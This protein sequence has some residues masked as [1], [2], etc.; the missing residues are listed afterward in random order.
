M[1]P[2]AAVD[3]SQPKLPPQ[4]LEA[5]QS[6]LGAILLDN[7]A[8]P[9]AMELL[10][11]EDFY[12][13][14]HRKI[15]RAMLDLSDVGEVIDQITLTERLKAKGE[16]ESVGGAA[17]LAELVQAV[18]SAANIRYHCKIVRDKAVAR[19]LT[20]FI[21]ELKK[22]GGVPSE[23]N[24][25]V[26]TTGVYLNG[27][28]GG[29]SFLLNYPKQSGRLRPIPLELADGGF[30]YDD[31]NGERLIDQVHQRRADADQDQHAVGSP[32]IG[33]DQLAQAGHAERLI[34][35]AHRRAARVDHA[36]L[37]RDAEV[38]AQQGPIAGAGM[39]AAATLHRR[40]TGADPDLAAIAVVQRLPVDRGQPGPR[41]AEGHRLR[42]QVAL[43]HLALALERGQQHPGE[44]R[45]HGR[46]DRDQQGM[47]RRRMPAR[48]PVAGARHHQLPA[49]EPKR[50][51]AAVMTAM[52]AK[53]ITDTAAA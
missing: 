20:G 5:E 27:R 8:M 16:L 29:Q 1:K 2:L 3:L 18:P 21:D 30:D 48:Q 11:E 35:E 10:V 52:K 41:R 37:H 7:Q 6:V 26:V 24:I 32:Q 28:V 44:R 46:P 47:E 36:V 23:F 45:E 19:E 38:I 15:Y 17:Y 9:K 12:R 49:L 51:F 4:N 31:P 43:E 53:R 25:G 34:A 42:D 50:Q 14:A 39:V 13:T 33:F 22:G 40:H